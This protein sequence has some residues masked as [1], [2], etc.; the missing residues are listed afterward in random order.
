MK[1]SLEVIFERQPGH[2]HVPSPWSARSSSVM[3]K[4][5]GG[6]ER[7][8][9]AREGGRKRKREREKNKEKKYGKEE[10]WNKIE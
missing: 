5:E 4:G 2:W 3:R 1:L 10:S 6:R 9:K 7:G 8:R